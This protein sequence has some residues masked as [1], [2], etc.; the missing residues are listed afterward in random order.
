MGLKQ[1]LQNPKFFNF[2]ALFPII[3][4]TI[5]AIILAISFNT[6]KT[7]SDNFKVIYDGKEIDTLE[8]IDMKLVPG[9][10]ASYQVELYSVV[11]SSCNITLD[12]NGQENAFS[13]FVTARIQ[14]EEDVQE[15]NLS[16]LLTSEEQCSF[17]NSLSTGQAKE[18]TISYNMDINATEAVANLELNFDVTFKVTKM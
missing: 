1:K 8:V 3:S 5:I 6:D 13:D 17:R 15:H 4:L 9:A 18:M 11:D 10:T 12:F 7:T 2:F 14:I 16:K